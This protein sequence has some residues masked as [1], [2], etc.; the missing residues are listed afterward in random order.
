MRR[1]HGIFSESP[2]LDGPL[3]VV[4][5]YDVSEMTSEDWLTLEIYGLGRILPI[6]GSGEDADT[7]LRGTYY[8]G[9]RRDPGD[10]G[11]SRAG[12]VQL[13]SELLDPLTRID[14]VAFDPLP[15]PDLRQTVELASLSRAAFVDLVLGRGRTWSSRSG[16]ERPFPRRRRGGVIRA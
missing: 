11:A 10:L 1:N 14:R 4:S 12:R 2:G 7:F 15:E 8:S 9:A 6:F 16:R 13:T 3:W 5:R